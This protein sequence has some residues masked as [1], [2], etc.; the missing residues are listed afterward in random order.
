MCP[1]LSYVQ[2][3]VMAGFGTLMQKCSVN[4]IRIAY[5]Q[6]RMFALS[7]GRDTGQD[8]VFGGGIIGIG[9]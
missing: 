3:L 7:F 2:P 6:G 1:R 5:W 4:K 9:N 8:V